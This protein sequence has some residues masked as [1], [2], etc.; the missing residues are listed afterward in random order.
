MTEVA[1]RAARSLRIEFIPLVSKAGALIAGRPPVSN[2]RKLPF[3][4]AAAPFAPHPQPPADRADDI[5]EQGRRGRDGED[6]EGDRARGVVNPEEEAAELGRRV[7]R[8][9]RIDEGV[10]MQ[11]PAADMVG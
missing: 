10:V 8:G 9:R 11:F 3:L 1:A 2:P 4:A 6:A 5:T 7:R